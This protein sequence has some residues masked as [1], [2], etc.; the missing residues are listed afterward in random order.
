MLEALKIEPETESDPAGSLLTSGDRGD[1]RPRF[2][3]WRGII[4]KI[5]CAPYTT[6]T[7]ELRATL[8]KGTLYIMEDPHTSRPTSSFNESARGKMMTYWGYRFEGLSTI[9]HDPRYLDPEDLIQQEQER[10]QY[11][12]VDTHVQFCSIVKTRVGAHD[13]FMGAEVDCLM[14]P[15][16]DASKNHNQTSLPSPLSSDVRQSLYAE[17]K[18]NRVLSNHNHTASFHKNKLLKTYFQCFLA[19]IPKVVVGFRDDHGYVESLKVFKTLEIPRM[20]RETAAA[21]GETSWDP[22]VCINWA[23]EVLS[24]LWKTLSKANAELVKG[25]NGNT[26]PVNTNDVVYRI[27]MKC[28]GDSRDKGR[29]DGRAQL[30]LVN[31]GGAIEIFPGIVDPSIAF[32]PT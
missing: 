8:H 12:V 26:D 20:V 17:L 25:Q 18:T 28:N 13:V 7:W 30:P 24:V 32:V 10:V 3:T 6:D 15:T 22:V 21:K 27:K 14:P 19:G 16:D 31:E 4:T 2:C 11:G 1:G 5:M 9:D 23:D 29:N